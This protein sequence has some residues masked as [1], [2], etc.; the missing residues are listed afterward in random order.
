MTEVCCHDSS[1]YR[2]GLRKHVHCVAGPLM[3]HCNG[4][5]GFLCQTQTTTQ[6]SQYHPTN[7]EQCTILQD[8]EDITIDYETFLNPENSPL[9]STQLSD[10]FMSDSNSHTT[11]ALSPISDDDALS[12]N[13]NEASLDS[14][15]IENEHEPDA[16]VGETELESPSS[17][18]CASLA[19]SATS[20]V[21]G[22]LA[23]HSHKRTAAQAAFARTAMDYDYDDPEEDRPF[24]CKAPGCGKCYTKASH[25]RAHTR[26]HTGERPFACVH[27]GCMWRFSRSDELS[28]HARKHTGV[29]PY[30]CRECGR[31][32]R[33][34][35]HLAA[36]IRIHER[37][38][39]K[40]QR[41]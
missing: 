31:R 7:V 15:E 26:S 14:E 19:S 33:R 4:E 11:Q 41:A 40:N 21:V 38:R 6:F 5:I 10:F 25:L 29:R 30:P 12:L 28:R 39:T 2:N 8:L 20:N 23:S 18:G 24:V 1:C 32:F 3:A 34:S 37:A 27:P 22:P 36:H 16:A 35:D 17:S 13:D 9:D